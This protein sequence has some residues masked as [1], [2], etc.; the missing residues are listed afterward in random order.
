MST[1]SHTETTDHQSVREFAATLRSDLAAVR[2]A[3]DHLREAEGAAWAGYTQDLDRIVEQMEL[4]LGA[5]REAL[6]AARADRTEDLNE[7]FRQVVDRA[8]QALDELR[9]QEAL[10]AAEVRDHL[11]DRWDRLTARVDRLRATVRDATTARGD[12]QRPL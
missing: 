4:D 1:T 11:G 6:A 2:E 7:A 3:H 10:A 8:H 9:V 5:E 12:R